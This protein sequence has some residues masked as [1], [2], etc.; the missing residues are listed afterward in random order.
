MGIERRER[1]ARREAKREE[2]ARRAVQ[3][4]QQR[5]A[6][7]RARVTALKPEVVDA[8]MPLAQSALSTEE[9][10]AMVNTAAAGWRNLPPLPTALALGAGAV[11]NR[12]LQVVDAA[13][14][15]IA[16][17]LGLK[18]TREVPVERWP[19]WV[20]QVMTA[21]APVIAKELGIATDAPE[22]PPEDEPLEARAARSG[23]VIAG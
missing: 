15:P 8:L 9:A 12:I 17:E 22:A 20:V 3:A 2:M 18:G 13:L 23:L 11:V 1:Q 6:L 16:D 4:A 10:Q 5:G 19:E 7:A 21:A 14:R